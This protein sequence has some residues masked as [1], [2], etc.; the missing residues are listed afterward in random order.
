MKLIKPS[1]QI[2]SPS[3]YTLDDIY[4]S[5]EIASRT[6]YKSED[7]ITPD[8]AKGFVDRMI[9]SGH[10]AMLEHG[11]V[12]LAIPYN[13]VS[14]IAQP[15]FKYRY[16]KYSKV[17]NDMCINNDIAYVTTNF[18]VLVENNWMDDLKYLCEP[19]EY[20][21]KRVTVKFICDRVT[22]ESFLRHRAIDEDHPTIEGEVTREMEK[23]IDS[24]ARESTRYCNYTKDKFNNQFTIITPPEF[25]E[26]PSYDSLSYFGDTDDKIF[27]NMCCSI[28]AG[29]IEEDF[30]IFETWMFANLAT[31][32]AYNRLISL[33]WQA[34][35]A[36]R[37][38]PLDIKSPLV[39]TAFISDW[40]HFFDL[41][42]DKAAHPQARELAIPL[43]EEFVKR[44]YIYE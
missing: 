21:E 9:K 23:D 38:I 39:M 14:S 20:H 43:Q 7:K 3:G 42:C 32:W 41:R 40:K 2:I 10:G 36:R 24:F 27:R 30:D 5:I 18:R 37:V 16:N 4:K 29:E 17:N 34:Q 8:S 19:T 22:G 44:G 11:T 31:Q 28:S 12:Y 1:F 35:Q 6:C 25:Y 15:H 33:G 13:I 26:G